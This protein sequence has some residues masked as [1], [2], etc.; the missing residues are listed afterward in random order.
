[1]RFSNIK[2]RRKLFLLVGVMLFIA[3][4]EF[5]VV[6]LL[7]DSVRKRHEMSVMEIRSEVYYHEAQKY[8]MA[9]YGEQDVAKAGEIYRGLIENIDSAFM[10]ERSMQT[11]YGKALNEEVE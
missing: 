8:L 2:M 9:Y 4:V 1:M 11:L 10:V 7:F 5:F 6:Y 3:L